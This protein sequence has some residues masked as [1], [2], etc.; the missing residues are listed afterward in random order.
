V[1]RALPYL[2]FA[3]IALACFWRFV[4]L[5]WT[6]YDVRTLDNH[7][8]VAASDTRDRGD[9]ILLLP[10]LHR[11][12]TEGL[13]QGELRLWNPYLF[14]GYP[15]TNDTQIHPFY[16]PNLALHA[17]LP[18]RAAYDL[19]LLLHFFFAGAAMYWLL[20]GLG[21]S[22]VA[23]TLGGVLWMLFGYN[24]HWVST[25]VLM[26]ASVFAP[27]A[28]LG[29]HLGLARRDYRPLA[30][31]GLS[32]GMVLLGSHGQHALHVTIFL[33]TWLLVSLIRDRES[34]PF[35]LKGGA[36]FLGS[37]LGV[38]MAAILTQLDAVTNG[39]RI[40]GEDVALHYAS[41]WYQ[42]VYIAGVAIGKVCVPP[43]GLMQSEFT[44]Y[45][46]VAGT[47]LAA[48]GAFRGFR[49]AWTRTLAI[50]AAAI[51]L[52]AFLKPLA[53][54]LLLVPFFNLSMPARWLYVF[55]LCLTIL[56]AAGLDAFREDPAK[57]TRVL[58]V[59]GAACLLAL[60]LF[61]GRGAWA[62]SL[63]GLVLAAAAMLAARRRPRAALALCFASILVDLLPNFTRFNVHADP[64]P[65]E[66]R[67]AAVD[68]L[69][70]DEPWRA[71]G[72]LRLAGPPGAV[73]GWTVSIGSNLLA[74]HGV[75]AVMGY[76][77]IA[78]LP[79][80]QLCYAISGERGIMGSGRVLA[81]I[82]L[83]SR[84]VDLAN[85]KYVFMPWAYEP[86]SR[87]RKVGATE[88]LAVYE[89]TAALPRA[90]LVSRALKAADENEAA[91]LLDS[92]DFDPRTTAVLQASELPRTGD[93]GGGV[94]WTWRGTDRIELA[95]EAKAD[96]ILVVSDTDYPG[97]EAAVDGVSTPI[98]RANLAFRAVAVPAGKHQVTMRFRPAS[99]RIGMIL[100]LLSGLA[101]LA[102][103]VRRKRSPS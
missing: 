58:A 91:R 18:Y 65:L 48:A 102:I 55:G 69:P 16:P 73:N 1:R 71:T 39:L 67:I 31:G 41:P 88:T 72:S 76:E 100:S 83:K 89:N 14:C 46:G 95:V 66:R 45:A 30:L 34:R 87:F 28:L 15:I 85:M 52:V 61:F 81:L 10:M 33:S 35:T 90:Y 42:P 7:L 2:V 75:E 77:A 21:R 38:G 53:E 79:T 97:W 37:G 82:N 63:V 26:G 64:A 96:S 59:G 84:L 101:A 86:D 25:G 60:L 93:G 99:A 4:F 92:K 5:G 24:S 80:A 78:P 94:T 23:A 49:D 40:P 27:L 51:L 19:N 44:L 98:L 9:T 50:F 8:G 57:S 32:L 29:L 43:G 68:A 36:L 62:E 12:Y 56:A 54:L 103:G 47:L 70:R 11:L 74:L 13:H 22:D 20:R 3:A 6:L 17:L